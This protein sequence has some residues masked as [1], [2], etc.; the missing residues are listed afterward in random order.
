M[1]AILQARCSSS[2]LPGKVLKPI[3]G[4]P[5][6]ARQIER[7]RRS[8]RITRLVVAT[9]DDPSDDPLS[10]L[11]A[12][13][14]I[15]CYRGS[16]NDVLD[17]FYQT[18]NAYPS[19]QLL[20]LT[21]DCPLADPELIDHCVD[22]HLSGDFDYTTNALQATFPDGLDVEVF[23]FKCLE[24]SWKE[25][26]LPSQR[27][28]VTPFIYGHPERYR[29]GHF[30]Q[31]QDLSALRWTVD[32]MTDLELVRGIYEHLYRSN[33]AFTT[34][35]IL[36][37]L[38]RYPNLAEINAGKTRNEGYQKSLADDRRAA[39]TPQIVKRG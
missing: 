27:E 25:A 12:N 2:R 10:A 33:P 1:L 39:A 30:R 15:C 26:R 18:A 6:I 21:G 38:A 32:C 11:C 31:H 13:R 29:I 7:L 3:L 23:R 36:A 34:N 5:M 9:S 19:D 24:E 16:L 37:L 20:R 35:D 8:Q 28:H 17:R 4:E 22:F 14:N